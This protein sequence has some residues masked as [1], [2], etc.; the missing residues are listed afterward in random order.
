MKDRIKNAA[1]RT[2]EW[3]KENADLIAV[4]GV[5]AA[6]IAGAIAIAIN[7][8]K[9]EADRDEKERVFRRDAAKKGLTVVTGPDGYLWMVDLK[10]Q[11]EA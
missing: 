10:D 7:V 5:Y 2:A 3:T 6:A 4:T 11:F 9:E 8:A 1:R